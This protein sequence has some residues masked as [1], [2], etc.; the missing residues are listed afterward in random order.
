VLQHTIAKIA[1]L[2]TVTGLWVATGPIAA[3]G[4]N[5]S[6]LRA[7]VTQW[8]KEGKTEADENEQVS[9]R[10]V[11]LNADGMPEALVVIRGATSCGSRSCSAF[12]LDLR[13]PAARSIGDFTAH[14]LEALSSRTGGWRDISV[15]GHRIRFRGGQYGG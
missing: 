3:Q 10:F 13:G 8:V 5:E 2:A 14:K 12:V 6:A 4:A 15:N 11:D 1:A 9:I 7:K